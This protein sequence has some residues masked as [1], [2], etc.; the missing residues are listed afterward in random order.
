M[1]IVRRIIAVF[2]LI[3]VIANCFNY[4]LVHES[5]EFNKEYISSVLCSNKG[6]PHLHCDGKCFLDIKLK[7]LEQKTKQEQENLKRNVETFEVAQTL[8]PNPVFE[9]LAKVENTNHLPQ[10]PIN[11][12][13]TI[14]HPPQIG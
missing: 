8:L 4:L 7:E 13:I 6:K 5:Y 12:S 3:G 1:L 10:K 2:L 14:F 9:I 11:R